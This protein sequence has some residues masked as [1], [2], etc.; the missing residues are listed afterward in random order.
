MKHVV[1]AL[2]KLITT[3]CTLQ[4]GSLKTIVKRLAL[5]C[6]SAK[7]SQCT[8]CNVTIFT[9]QRFGDDKFFSAEIW[10]WVSFTVQRIGSAAPRLPSRGSAEIWSWVSF[11]V[12]R[13]GSAAPRLPSRGS[14]PGT[15]TLP[16]AARTAMTP[17]AG[18]A[19]EAD[20]GERQPL[21]LRQPPWGLRRLHTLEIFSGAGRAL[22]AAAA[23]P[24]ATGWRGDTA[25][26][27][28][29]KPALYRGGPK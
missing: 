27:M 16:L 2:V 29:Q 14:A 6:F 3:Y 22:L 9:V 1:C 5:S 25:A 24:A 13:I 20:I 21:L 17:A 4:G 26:D 7:G 12:Q 28:K 19:R 18:T 8:D 10:S 11:T 15:A 23:A